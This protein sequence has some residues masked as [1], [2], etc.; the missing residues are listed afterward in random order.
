[1]S[2]T[3]QIYFTQAIKKHFPEFFTGKKVLEVGSLDI[4]GSVR[5]L[6]SQGEYV[7]IDLELG[8]G[9]DHAVPG[10]LADFKTGSFDVV[11]TCNCFEHNPYWLETFSNMCRMA[12]PGGLFIMTVAGYGFMEHGTTR[13]NPDDSPFTVGQ[14]WEYYRNLSERD[15][16]V[17]DMNNWFSKWKFIHNWKSKDLYFV[18]VLKGGEGEKYAAAIDAVAQDYDKTSNNIYG[19]LCRSFDI[20]NGYFKLRGNIRRIRRSWSKRRKAEKAARSVN[21][22]YK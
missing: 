16:A 4:N 22:R 18:G 6:F 12:K 1:M 15:F 9:V 17:L 13:T 8:N 21:Q 14:G 3:E 5:E 7:G 20:T 11:V 2:H 10:Q 19:Y